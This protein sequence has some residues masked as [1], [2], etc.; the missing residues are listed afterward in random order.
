MNKECT[1]PEAYQQLDSFMSAVTA[2]GYKPS[3]TKEIEIVIKHYLREILPQFKTINMHSLSFFMK[4]YNKRKQKTVFNFNLES[5]LKFHNYLYRGCLDPS[6]KHI[7]WVARDIFP[8]DH[9]KEY[10]SSFHAKNKE[11]TITCRTKAVLLFLCTQKKNGAESINSISLAAVTDYL[12]KVIVEDQRYIRAY[13]HYLYVNGYI[14]VN[15]ADLIYIEKRPKKLPS[16]YTE[17]EIVTLIN[18]IDLSTI[19]GIR[20]KAIVLLAARLGL[21][22]S[23]IAGLK[24][25]NIDFYR[26][27][28]CIEQ[29]KTDVPLSLPIDDETLGVIQKYIE[30]RSIHTSEFLFL[31]QNA[32]YKHMSA[33]NVRTAINNL[34]KKSGI[35]IC[36]RKHG[37]HALRSSL[38]SAMASN[39]VDY[40][41]IQKVLGHTSDWSLNQYIRTDFSK[42][43]LCALPSKE[44]TGI[45]Q[46]WL[47]GEGV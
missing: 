11:Q 16:V 21:R 3:T 40:E 6:R 10:I 9:F 25:E 35:D 44:P 39:D 22:E 28:I 7:Q 38:A 34:F 23:D 20:N 29:Y 1:I 2:Y 45:F 26:K 18:S 47:E 30:M 8:D 13:L 27:K 12:Q 24:I 37:P 19:C 14:R 31:N 43:K 42:L 41:I 15:I 46:R 36:D 32:P 5:C 33:C 17:S 4:R